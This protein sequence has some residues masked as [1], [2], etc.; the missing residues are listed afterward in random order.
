MSG[1]KLLSAGLTYQLRINSNFQYRGILLKRFGEEGEGEKAG[2]R[3]VAL[4]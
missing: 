2:S 3:P 4:A 1:M